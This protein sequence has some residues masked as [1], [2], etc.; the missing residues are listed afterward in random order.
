V[1]LLEDKHMKFLKATFLRNS[2]LALIGIFSANPA[3]ALV[4]FGVKGGINLSSVAQTN[5]AG[6][7]VSSYTT[8]GMG[9]EGGLGVDIG[10][11]PIGVLV[12]VLYAHRSVGFGSGAIAALNGSDLSFNS[13][14]V[15]VQARFS[16]IPMLSLTGGLYYSMIMGDGTLTSSSG[17]ETTLT[18]ADSAKKDFGLVG[19]VGVSLPLG[20]TTLTLEAR[21]LYGLKNTADAPTGD[22]SSKYRAIDVLAGVTF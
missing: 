14:L 11:G 7:S 3:Q 5:S 13:L 10:L 20:V 1:Q 2:A 17:T 4:S 9:Y 22:E 6:T 15:P 16:I 21:Y 19:G 18:F 12:D 8:Q